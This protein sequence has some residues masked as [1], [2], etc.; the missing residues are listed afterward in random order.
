MWIDGHFGA[1][2]SGRLLLPDHE[3]GGLKAVVAPLARG[4]ADLTT[5]CPTGRFGPRPGQAIPGTVMAA[6]TSASPPDTCASVLDDVRSSG[7]PSLATS[8]AR[9]VT[10]GRVDQ[11]GR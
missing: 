7:A 1:E 5:H 8:E 2:A 6:S 10:P 9:A 3:P 4:A 11:M